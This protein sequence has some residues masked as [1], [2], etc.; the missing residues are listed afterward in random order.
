MFDAPRRVS[1]RPF[2]FAIRSAI[3]TCAVRKLLVAA[4]TMLLIAAIAFSVRTLG[5]R[6]EADPVNAKEA[7]QL[8]EDQGGGPE[9]SGQGEQVKPGRRPQAGTYTYE[10]SGTEGVSVLGGSEHEFPKEIPVVVK[11]DAEDDCRWT[12]NVIYVEQ[13][14]EERRYCTDAQGM[15]DLGFTRRIEFFNRPHTEKHDCGHPGGRRLDLD[16]KPGATASWKCTLEDGEVVSAY[17]ATYVGRE[18]QDV[19]GEQVETWHVRVV[20]RQS[21]AARGGDTSEFGYLETGQPARFRGDLDVT[22]DLMLGTTRWRERVDYRLAS[23]VP[24]G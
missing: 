14:V 24:H 8:V 10:G 4:L 22:T 16:A 5:S 15:L 11:L 7:K 21:G 12:S 23:L 3:Q 19:G 17:A 9:Q 2:R 20:S 1:T 18:Q 13:H 6:D